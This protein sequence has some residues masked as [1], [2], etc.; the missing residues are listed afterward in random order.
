MR[1]KYTREVISCTVENSE[2]DANP[3]VHSFPIERKDDEGA[4]LGCAVE[5]PGHDHIP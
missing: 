4:V 3:S 2:G 1:A 5:I